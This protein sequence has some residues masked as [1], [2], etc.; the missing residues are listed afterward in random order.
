[1]PVGEGV[2]CGSLEVNSVVEL[3][4]IPVDLVKRVIVLLIKVDEVVCEEAERGS[5]LFLNRVEGLLLLIVNTIIAL[6]DEVIL[7]SDEVKRN[8]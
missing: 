2:I 6:S 3:A 5:S 8:L 1:M 7:T 4:I